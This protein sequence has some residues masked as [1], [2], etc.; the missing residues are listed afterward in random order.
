MADVDKRKEGI[1]EGS[2]LGMAAKGDHGIALLQVLEL[3]SWMMIQIDCYNHHVDTV[4]EAIVQVGVEIQV[5]DYDEYR[6]WVGEVTTTIR[7][8]GMRSAETSEANHLARV[9]H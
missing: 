9:I 7:F 3:T 4:H 2:S 1:D 5:T 6:Q 8:D